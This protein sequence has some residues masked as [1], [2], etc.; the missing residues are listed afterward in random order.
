MSTIDKDKNPKG[1]TILT[2]SILPPLTDSIENDEDGNE[3]TMALG[4][5]D[6]WVRALYVDEKILIFE[7]DSKSRTYYLSDNGEWLNPYNSNG[8]KM[9]YATLENKPCTRSP[10]KYSHSIHEVQ[11]KKKKNQKQKKKKTNQCS[12]RFALLFDD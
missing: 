2:K 5:G 10:C 4:P 9:C 1:A 8:E 3:I 12:N 7:Q 11:A 6:T